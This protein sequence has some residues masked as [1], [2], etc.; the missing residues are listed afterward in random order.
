MS[1]IIKARISLN[2][3]YMN[4]LVF[5]FLHMVYEKCAYDLNGKTHITY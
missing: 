1:N 3:P 4:R 2:N 5:T